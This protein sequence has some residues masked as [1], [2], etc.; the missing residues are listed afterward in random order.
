MY[1]YICI[2]ID[3]YRY[4]SVT[5][6]N[7]LDIMIE[8]ES[9]EAIEAIRVKADGK[10]TVDLALYIPIVVYNCILNTFFGER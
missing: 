8:S 5:E 10:T 1:R 6:S 9:Q 2:F 4:R 3:I 7:P